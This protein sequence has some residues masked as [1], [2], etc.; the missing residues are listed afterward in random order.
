MAFRWLRWARARLD[1]LDPAAVTHVGRIAANDYW[2]WQYHAQVGIVLAQGPV[3]DNESSKIYY[4]LR[5]GLPTVCEESIPN[6]SLI[7]E[8]GCGAIVPYGDIEAMAEAAAQ[9][10]AI[11]RSQNEVAEYMVREHS[12]D[13]RAALYDQVLSAA[14]RPARVPL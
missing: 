6:K 2:D 11:P 8:T 1:H 14:G 5:T 4:Y 3:Q 13:A 12:W 9:V 7:E 10:V